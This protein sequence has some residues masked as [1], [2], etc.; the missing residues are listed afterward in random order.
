MKYLSTAETANKW[1]ISQRRVSLLC[2]EGRIY[3]AV[4]AGKTWI[5]PET[6]V[7]PIDER[8][9]ND[10]SV[11]EPYIAYGSSLN[12]NPE[13]VKQ[14]ALYFAS[15]G[16]SLTEAVNQF[17]YDSVNKEKKRI[18]IGKGLFSV[19]DDI[20]FCNEEIADMFGV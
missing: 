19:P 6:S 8:A 1:G 11:S 3:G 15:K 18:G 20:D 2:S 5:I 4:K 16:E 17:L 10:I 12:L 14:A 9:S 13:L 7:K